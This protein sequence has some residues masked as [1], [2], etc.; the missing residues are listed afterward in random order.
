MEQAVHISAA[1][2]TDFLV[3]RKCN[4]LICVAERLSPSYCVRDE[5]LGPRL[6]RTDALR[7]YFLTR[8]HVHSS[9][10][11]KPLFCS[12]EIIRAEEVGN[13][14]NARSQR[15]GS[16]LQ[17]TL[18]ANSRP[19]SAWWKNS[20]AQGVSFCGVAEKRSVSREC[21]FVSYKWEKRFAV[22][23]NIITFVW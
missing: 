1:P 2:A 6:I 3:T 21:I 20:R 14:F 17:T 4:L 8:L 12:R 7:D 11:Q 22:L 15:K 5:N 9:H 18:K 23:R 13:K 16:E 19:G 10:A